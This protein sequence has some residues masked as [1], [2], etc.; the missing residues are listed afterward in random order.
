MSGHRPVSV[1]RFGLV[2]WF[3]LTVENLCQATEVTVITVIMVM[4][5]ITATMIRTIKR[6]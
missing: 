4:E 6:P 3:S 1:W 5:M 2:Q